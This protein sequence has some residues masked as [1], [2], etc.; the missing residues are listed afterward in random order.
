MTTHGR[1]SRFNC[2]HLSN[3]LAPSEVINPRKKLETIKEW[4]PL[5]PAFTIKRN[6]RLKKF[7]TVSQKE[8]INNEG[9]QKID[10]IT[11]RAKY[12]TTLLLII[13]IV[14]ASGMLLNRGLICVFK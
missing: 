14:V 7:P 5:G 4:T 11:E 6:F 8:N 12:F 10:K 13:M 1:L 3:N 9:I 2:S